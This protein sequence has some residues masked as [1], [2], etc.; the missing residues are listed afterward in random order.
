MVHVDATRRLY[1]PVSLL[2]CIAFAAV[3]ILFLLFPGAAY[4]LFNDLSPRLGMVEAPV[5]ERGLYLVLGVAYMYLVAL[6][7]MLMYRHPANRYFPLLLINAKG[8]SALLSVLL[9]F[10]HGPYL[11]YLANALVDGLIAIGVF[12]LSLHV[13]RDPS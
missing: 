11:I 12:L 7:A 3:G 6:L 10:V 13:G 8:A 1:R 5:Q 4:R 2:L 9:F